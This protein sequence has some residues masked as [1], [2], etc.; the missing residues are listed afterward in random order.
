MLASGVENHGLRDFYMNLLVD[1]IQERF[2]PVFRSGDLTSREMDKIC[3]AIE[4]HSDISIANVD[5]GR[6][7]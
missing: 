4:V 6:N 5:V 3:D 7:F 1:P 2:N